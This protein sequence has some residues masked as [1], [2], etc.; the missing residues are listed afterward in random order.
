M[1]DPTPPQ[2]LHNP[3][4]PDP[5][6][7]SV[8]TN[9]SKQPQMVPSLP[10]PPSTASAPSLGAEQ[11]GFGKDKCVS[12]P[13]VSRSI[14]T[15]AHGV[16]QVGSCSALGVARNTGGCG[17]CLCVSSEPSISP[18]RRRGPGGSH[19]AGMPW[20]GIPRW[21]NRSTPAPFTARPGLQPPWSSRGASEE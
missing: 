7:W 17:G 9:V 6:R 8:L 1:G 19:R 11:Q 18:S 2:P 12:P 20:W 13:N 16:S 4:S 3:G 10:R 21:Q 5:P 14:H 15:T